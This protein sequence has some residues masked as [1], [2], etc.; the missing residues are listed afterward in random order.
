MRL[1]L[2]DPDAIVR[3]DGRNEGGL[4][5]FDLLRRAA[6]GGSAV[7]GGGL[8]LSRV[9]KAFAQGVTDVDILNLLLVNEA[10]EAAF[11]AEAVASGNLR[12]EALAFARQLAANEAVH[13][14]TIAGALGA[15]ARPLPAFEFGNTTA[16]QAA[17]IRTS[18]V[19]ENNDVAANNGAGPL[20][21][22]KQ[23]LAVAG[24]IVSVEGRQ[25]AW[26]RRLAYGPTYTRTQYPAPRAFDRG[27]T[28]E[29][30]QRAVA[31]YGFIQGA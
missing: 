17:F 27:I 19:L 10:M 16:S 22:S 13:R 15:N 1:E 5:R 8:L 18:L 4:T 20:L 3:G 23:I 2:V 6:I 28:L 14:D 9:P 31:S 25:A 29:Q 30:A 7:L 11:Y 24:Q 26:I 12:G 21:R